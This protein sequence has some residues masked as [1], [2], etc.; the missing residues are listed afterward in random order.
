MDIFQSAKS[1]CCKT[2]M[3]HSSSTSSNA[4]VNRGGETETKCKTEVLLPKL[5]LQK[6]NGV[7]LPQAYGLEI[8]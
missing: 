5:S 8:N 3:G 6:A 7:P 1:N 4:A 2:L